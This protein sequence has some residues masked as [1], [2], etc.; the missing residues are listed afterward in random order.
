MNVLKNSDILF[1]ATGNLSLKE[2]E[3]KYLK[4][5]SFLFSVTSS[6]DEIDISW[7][8]NKYSVESV[9]KYIKKYEKNGHYF[10]IAN[11]GNAVNFIH[12][13][14][15]DDFILLVQKEMIDT[16]LELA[17]NNFENKIYNGFGNIK[18][19]IADSW[20]NKILHLNI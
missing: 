15:V 2:A 9:S 8:E 11:D 17:K 12:G 1:L 16:I 10:F 14:V 4:N 20:L 19:R 7:L 3:Y 6:D 13:A 5:G 18:E